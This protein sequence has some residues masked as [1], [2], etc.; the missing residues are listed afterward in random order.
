MSLCLNKS[1][2]DR[3]QK[4]VAFGFFVKQLLVD[5]GLLIKL[6]LKVISLH[7]SF[8][9]LLHIHIERKSP[10]SLESVEKVWSKIPSVPGNCS[11]AFFSPLCTE[12]QFIATFTLQ[13]DDAWDCS[14]AV[15]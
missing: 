13:E 9:E 11:V 10:I 1:R 12:V 8:H 2:F 15:W 3:V 4:G 7:H 14:V 6:L 5:F